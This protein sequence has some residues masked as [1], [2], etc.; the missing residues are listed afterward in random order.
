MIWKLWLDDD[1]DNP[2]AQSTRAVPDGYTPAR[3]TAEA[4]ALIERLGLPSCMDL[5]FDL[6]MTDSV[7][8][9]SDGK[10][11]SAEIFLKWLANRYPDD[12]PVYF[13]HSRNTVGALWIDSFMK[14]WKR[15]LE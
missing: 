12:P 6:G 10:K 8:G 15:S 14:S 9:F 5:D 1:H 3:S 11:D 2:I 7:L 13:I 4:I